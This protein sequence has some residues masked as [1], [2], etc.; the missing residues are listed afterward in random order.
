MELLLLLS[1]LLS[2]SL[3]FFLFL[4]PNFFEEDFVFTC[5]SFYLSEGFIGCFHALFC[6]VFRFQWLLGFDLVSA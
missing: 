5:F 2:A 6:L 3:S 1:S 4:F